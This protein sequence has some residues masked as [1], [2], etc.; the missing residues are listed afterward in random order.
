MKVCS[1]VPVFCVEKN[2][3]SL[4]STSLQ[5]SSI[6]DIFATHIGQPKLS[7]FSPLSPP[8]LSLPRLPNP[9][10]SSLLYLPLNHSHSRSPSLFLSFSPSLYPLSFSASL[11][12]CLLSIT[13]THALPSLLFSFSLY[14]LFSIPISPSHCPTSSLSLSLS[15]R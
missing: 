4:T 7:H 10:F 15:M 5:S 13:T 14:S 11:S 12:L 9:L 6:S 8:S 1:Q 3:E 2:V